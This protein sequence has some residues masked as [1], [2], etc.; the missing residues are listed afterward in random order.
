MRYFAVLGTTRAVLSERARPSPRPAAMVEAESFGSPAFLRSHTMSLWFEAPF[1]VTLWCFWKLGV[2]DDL[3]P[4]A[5][6]GK[7][8]CAA[9]DSEGVRELN[10]FP[11]FHEWCDSELLWATPTLPEA[12]SFGSPAFLRSHTMSLWFEA[13]FTV[14]LWCF[15]KLGVSDDLKPFAVVGK[16]AC[17]AVDSEGVRE[18]NMSMHFRDL[19]SQVWYLTVSHPSLPGC[20]RPTLV[21]EFKNC[22]WED[23]LLTPL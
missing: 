3:K 23:I 8:A 17:A 12:E 10:M 1:T 15:W 14:T 6:V 11:M 20:M 13:P 9:V 22:Q 2:S 16:R 19:P 21:V 5:V 4:F 18:L 7:R